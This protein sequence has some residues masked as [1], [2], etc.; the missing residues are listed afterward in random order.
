M[1]LLQANPSR[2]TPK[3]P[4]HY[5]GHQMRDVKSDSKKYFDELAPSYTRH[6]YGRHG[7]AGPLYGVL[8]FVG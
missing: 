4:L 2:L 8:H 5:F 3:R 7:R 6:Y 1:G